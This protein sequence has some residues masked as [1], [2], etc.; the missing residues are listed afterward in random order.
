M[1]LPF[2]VMGRG[3]GRM[4]AARTKGVGGGVLRIATNRGEIPTTVTLAGANSLRA[5]TRK[6]V[7]FGNADLEYI[8]LGYAGFYSASGLEVN[9]GN[10]QSIQA[11]IEGISGG[12]PGVVR[13]TFDGGNSVGT[14]VDGVALY[15]SDRLYAS[16]FGL[17]KFPKNTTFF[18]REQ[19]DVALGKNHTRCSSIASMTGERTYLSDGQSASQLMST[20]AMSQPTG[21][22]GPARMMGP[23][24]IIGKSVGAT[25]VA[26]IGIG[27]SIMAGS[28]DTSAPNGN[29]GS[30]GGGF[31]Q[32][33]L[34]SVNGRTIPFLQMGVSGTK[35]M[36][37]VTSY[38]KRAAYFR[39]AT[40]LLE[41]FGTNDFVDSARTAA[42]VYA[43]RQT[44]WAAFKAAAQGAKRVE[45]FP[46]LPRTNSTDSWATL[47]N[48][49]PRTG[50][51]ASSGTFRDPMN[52]NL[53]T[54]LSGGL[55][56]GIID[57]NAAIADV[58]SPDKWIV[59]GAANFAT[60][61]GTH[62]SP[63]TSASPYLAAAVATRAATW[64]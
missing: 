20:G 2:G 4:G 9:A 57:L 51:A 48:Q 31:V 34:Y 12:S 40:H 58:G 15:L 1:P 44:I 25:E 61:D 27:D 17:T 39:Y 63:A 53:A 59:T 3:F 29:D 49:T 54:A 62:P 18:V 60:S 43:D 14:I 7:K 19:R 30:A 35:A 55:I 52:A 26:V 13:V 10:D 64:A 21:G 32:R 6:F 33:G 42:Q 28:N 8:Q 36:D 41:N 56:D 38:A 45:A 46:I 47:A 50:Y 11:A 16:A 5:E 24:V 37:F 22:S 23:T